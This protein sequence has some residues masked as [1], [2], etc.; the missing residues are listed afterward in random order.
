MSFITEA[1]SF[2]I[3]T[4][5]HFRFDAA[6]FSLQ[7]S[8]VPQKGL[9]TGSHRFIAIWRVNQKDPPR[10]RQK[11]KKTSPTQSVSLVGRKRQR[12]D[13]LREAKLHSDQL[14]LHFVQTTWNPL[15]ECEKSSQLFIFVRRSVV[16]LNGHG[17]FTCPF[18]HMIHFRP[19]SAHRH[20]LLVSE[21]RSWPQSP[22]YAA[23]HNQFFESI[24][25]K[26]DFEN[27]EAL[28]TYLYEKSLEIQPKD[29]EKPLNDIRPKHPLAALKS[30]GIKPPKCSNHYGGH[31]VP[32]HSLTAPNTPLPAQETK[33]S[34]SH[35]SSEDH[36][37]AS[38]EASLSKRHGY[39]SKRNQ[40]QFNKIAPLQPPP[41]VHPRSSRQLPQPLPP[42]TTNAPTAPSAKTSPHISTASSS[43]T[44]TTSTPS[45][46]VAPAP[47][48]H[49]RRVPP[50]SM[51]PH[52]LSPHAKSPLTPSQNGANSP[53]A[54]PFPTVYDLASTPPQLPPKSLTSSVATPSSSS[55][56]ENQEQLRVTLDRSSS[57]SH[58]PTVCLSVPLPPALPPP[59]GS[60][61][62]HQPPPLP[63]KKGRATPPTSAVETTSSGAT[64]VLSPPPLPPKTFRRAQQENR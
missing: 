33:R 42:P 61:V 55:S 60:H 27:D 13:V 47:K 39:D 44:T 9:H 22:S 59:R 28:E 64:E 17:C 20:H 46:A 41:P 49:P 21:R 37:F 38:G 35:T 58:S 2:G 25:P 34:H 4:H 3:C 54:F 57:E 32:H 12:G 10:N 29:T 18:K 26:S 6:V 48:L 11:E 24:N 31:H 5:P 23:H 30:P 52:A 19:I 43:P 50:A 40:G 45:S 51:S 63:P 7:L 62:N 14:V 53:S 8:V 36:P 1:L 15:S 16:N 56:K